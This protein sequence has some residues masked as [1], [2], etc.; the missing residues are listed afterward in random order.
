MAWP[1]CAGN[2]PAPSRRNCTTTHSDPLA[3]TPATAAA[4]RRRNRLRSTPPPAIRL[5][6]AIPQR[7][8]FSRT[9]GHSTRSVNHLWLSVRPSSNTRASS[10]VVSRPLWAI[11]SPP[12]ALHHRETLAPPQTARL[13]HCTSAAGRH[14]APESV[15]ARAAPGAGLVGPLGRHL[16]TLAF[17]ACTTTLQHRAHY[18]RGARYNSR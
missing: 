17:V 3:A 8:E 9:S 5:P 16:P 18:G 1:S 4:T 11:S 15:R 2:T 12:G 7:T 14:P 10:A 6:T 13:Q